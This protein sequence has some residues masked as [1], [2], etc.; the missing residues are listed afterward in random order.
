[1]VDVVLS[2]VHH[3]VRED[4]PFVTALAQTRD[5]STAIAR[6]LE[7]IE[8][9]VRPS[10][11]HGEGAIPRLETLLRARLLAGLRRGDLAS[12][13]QIDDL[14]AFYAN[15]AVSLLVEAL[16]GGEPERLSAIRRV[17]MRIITQSAVVSA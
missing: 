10:S 13:A 15:V 12:D 16:S 11:Q 7:T 9:D 17:A 8:A 5:T 2:A 3:L 4:G 6:A 14:S 1:M